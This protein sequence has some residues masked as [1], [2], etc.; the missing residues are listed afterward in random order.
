MAPLK[1]IERS[2]T[3]GFCPLTAGRTLLAA[4]TVAGAIDGSFNTS[5]TLDIFSLDL[6][7]GS[8]A[9]KLA[10]TVAAPERFNRLAWG[11]APRDP[12]SMPV[13]WA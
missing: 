12:A 7:S 2:A 10:G 4:G 5:A 13:S 1:Q 11:A 3:V 6:A 9:P 8:E